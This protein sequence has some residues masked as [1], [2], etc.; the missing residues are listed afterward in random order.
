MRQAQA[1]Q[2]ACGCCCVRN[3]WRRPGETPSAHATAGGKLL[4]SQLTDE[5]VRALYPEDALPALTSRTV[6]SRGE[7]FAELSVVRER[8]FAVSRGESIAGM[9]AAVV[10]LGGPSWLNRPALMA[11]VPADRGDDAALVRWAGELQRPAAYSGAGDASTELGEGRRDR[12]GDRQSASRPTFD[13]EDHENR[14]P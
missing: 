2:G 6:T 1:R 7:L 3:P 4:L 13:T 5:Q 10:P 11:S 9:H 14:R 8:G 12:H